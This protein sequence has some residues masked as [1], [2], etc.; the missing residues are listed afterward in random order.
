[1]IIMFRK[2]WVGDKIEATTA[3]PTRAHR[4]P[5]RNFSG[6]THPL[7]LAKAIRRGSSK[8]RPNTKRN[9]NSNATV[10]STLIK[11]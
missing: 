7:A 8:I 1:M 4:R 2:S 5:F 10:R 3:F 6:V 9:R 11:A